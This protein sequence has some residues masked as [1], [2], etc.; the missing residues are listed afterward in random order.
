[1]DLILE[2]VRNGRRTRKVRR[3]EI[4]IWG[5]SDISDATTTAERRADQL[6]DHGQI[7]K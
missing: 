1:M 6:V 3:I 2:R 4:L 7:E 5:R